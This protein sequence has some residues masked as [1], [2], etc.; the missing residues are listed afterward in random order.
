MTS[1]KMLLGGAA[2]AAIVAA[3]FFGWSHYFPSSPLIA[4]LG[5]P[6]PRADTRRSCGRQVRVY[7]WVRVPTGD[8]ICQSSRGF[9]EFWNQQEVD[10]DPLTRGVTHVGRMLAPPDSTIW[11]ASRDSIRYVMKSD[12]GQPIP[13]HPFWGKY[14]PGTV[15]V[16]A[17]RFAGHTVRLNAYH[18]P[19]RPENDNG[20]PE[21]LLQLD[22]YPGDPPGCGNLQPEVI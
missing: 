4:R 2:A 10:L 20:P 5:L 17:W 3:A 11:A 1:N 12:G 19:A 13:C 22:G 6:G 8:I 15:S 14:A 16:E 21:W 9:A 18:W 7:R